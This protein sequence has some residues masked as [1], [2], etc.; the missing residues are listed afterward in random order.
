MAKG[1][2]KIPIVQMKKE[3]GYAVCDTDLENPKPVSR[4]ALAINA[5]G[6]Q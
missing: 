3:V 4:P 1:M 5:H 6:G 2:E